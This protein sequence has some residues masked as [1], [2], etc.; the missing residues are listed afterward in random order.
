MDDI[1]NVKEQ[2][3]EPSRLRGKKQTYPKKRTP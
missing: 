1:N 2:L 3:N